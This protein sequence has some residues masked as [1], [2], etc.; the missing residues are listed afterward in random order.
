[1][2]KNHVQIYYFTFLFVYVFLNVSL[3]AGITTIVGELTTV[4]DSVPEVLARNLPKASN[5]FFSYILIHTFTT[6]AYTL[7][8][9]GG[10]VQVLVLS[11][12]LDKTARQKW[13]K[14][15]CLGLHKW[16][17][18]IPVLTIIYNELAARVWIT[19]A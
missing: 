6:I 7:L 10:L 4:V 8:Q 15:E 3:S 13:A 19:R 1:V 12:F 16:G 2:I 17:T 11:L 9:L 18:F 5:Y 14:V